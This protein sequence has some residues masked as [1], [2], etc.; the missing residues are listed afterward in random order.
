MNP[1]ERRATYSLA[2]IFSMRMLG[3]FMVLP[4]LALEAQSFTNSTPLLIGL[5]IGAYGLTQAIL[6]IPFGMASD[7]FGRKPVILFGLAL[8]AAGSIVAALSDT[9]YGI[10]IGRAIQ[11]SGAI[12]AVITALSADLTREENRT[13]AMAVIGMTIGLSFTLS[14]ILGP[15]FYQWLGLSG[16][17]WATAGLAV[18]GMVILFKFVPQPTV[19]KFHRET[20][21]NSADFSQIIRNGLLLRLDFGIFSLHMILTA[22]FVALPL[23]LHQQ[24]G[25]DIPYHGYLYAGTLLLAMIFMFP[26]IIIAEKYRKMKPVFAAAVATLF[27]S[28]LGFAFTGQSLFS[29]GFFLFVFFLGFNV[30]E[31][32]LPSLI[33]K[34]APS[35]KKGTAMGIYSTSQ[36][37]GAFAGG[38]LGGLI[39][40]RWETTGIFIFCALIALIWFGVASTMTMP[41]HLASRMFSIGHLNASEC[42]LLTQEVL[43]IEGVKEAIFIPDDGVAYL[44]VD[45]KTIDNDTLEYFFKQQPTE[46]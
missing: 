10:I 9:L 38:A 11:G 14:M 20:Q 5:A 28:C 19:N 46:A 4:V 41:R 44:K 34:A 24:A 37:L 15:L 17:F 12:A 18:F 7:R 13:K 16:L 1:F 26:F 36:F 30:L 43:R 42:E 8:F 3:L 25:L 35:E 32:T 31:A 22:L 23:T 33:A 27:I 45:S 40:G 21:L 2:G 6:Q 39:Y 29:I